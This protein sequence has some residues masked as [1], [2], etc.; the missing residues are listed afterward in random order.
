MT[1]TPAEGG[2]SRGSAENRATIGSAERDRALQPCEQRQ[3][4]VDGAHARACGIADPPPSRRSSLLAS[5]ECV[6]DR[7]GIDGMR[8]TNDRGRRVESLGAIRDLDVQKN[9]FR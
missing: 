7:H 1:T 4:L 3:R 9:V 6:Q 2:A 5:L 8:V